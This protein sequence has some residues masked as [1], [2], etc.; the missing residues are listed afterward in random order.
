MTNIT[1]SVP[2]ELAQAL[3]SDPNSLAEVLALG[4]Q[5]WQADP[6]TVIDLTDIEK[7][8]VLRGPDEIQAF[9]KTAP[10]LVDLLKAAYPF[11]QK[12]F[13]DNVQ[14][15]LEVIDD[16]EVEDWRTLFGYILTSLPVDEAL[17][18]LN[19]FDEG[20]L[21]HQSDQVQAQL[22]FNLEFV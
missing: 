14:V 18:R 7:V 22:A 8:Y 3:P 5:Q 20:W 6:T 21:A 19:R 15:A 10:Y 11:L 9:L 13:G 16:P 12:Q 4:L 17:S 2:P 1:L